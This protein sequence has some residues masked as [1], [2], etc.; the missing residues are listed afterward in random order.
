MTEAI[1]RRTLLIGA[2]ATMLSSGVDLAAAETK[3]REEH[4]EHAPG[5][6]S[7]A[8]VDAAAACEKEGEACVAH[9]LAAFRAGDTT[10][11]ACA[12]SV[13]QMLAACTAAG[14]LASY[15]SPHLPAFAKVC[16]DICADCER[17]C[18]KHEDR[19]AICRACADACA[20]FVAAARALS[21]E[22]GVS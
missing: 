9:C 4:Q 13:V 18:R 15:G 6:G 17:E 1:S 10:L 11:G 19:H 20:R 3:G 21:A 14:R 8:V 2:G 5:P 7:R 12:T 16:S 22:R